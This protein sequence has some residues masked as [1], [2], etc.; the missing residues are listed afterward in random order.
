M[1]ICGSGTTRSGCRP[2]EPTDGR[3]WRVLPSSGAWTRGCAASSPAAGPVST[4]WRSRAA[5][6]SSSGSS[7]SRTPRRTSATSSPSTA[8]PHSPGGSSLPALAHPL[9]DLTAPSASGLVDGPLERAQREVKVSPEGAFRVSGLFPGNYVLKAEGV[10]VLRY[11][12]WF[13]ALEPIDVPAEGRVLERPVRV[14]RMG[15]I[16]VQFLQPPRPGTARWIGAEVRIDSADGAGYRRRAAMGEN[17]EVAMEIPCGAYDVVVERDRVGAR[18]GDGPCPPAPPAILLLD[19]APGRRPD[20][21]ALDAGDCDRDTGRAYRRSPSS[22]DRPRDTVGG[23]SRRPGL[24]ARDARGGARGSACGRDGPSAE[25]DAGA[26]GDGTGEP[27]S[28]DAR[29]AAVLTGGVGARRAARAVGGRAR[30]RCLG[31]SA[32]GADGGGC[33]GS[34][35]RGHTRRARRGRTRHA[36]RG[37]PRVPAYVV[38]VVGG[39]DRRGRPGR[40]AGR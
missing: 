2:R 28:A 33:G 30:P 20:A 36:D 14:V 15:S 8:A 18:H 39:D 26:P 23:S 27:G 1:S 25:V 35:D 19:G 9:R 11:G 4:R 22:E 37:G 3:R 13:E 17:G 34:G 6:A 38:Q 10:D 7:R 5:T 24:P 16:T 32:H 40:R 29:P 21:L 31:G 12:L